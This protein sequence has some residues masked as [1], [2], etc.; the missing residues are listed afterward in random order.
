MARLRRPIAAG[1][2]LMRGATGRNTG[3]QSHHRHQTLHSSGDPPLT[4]LPSYSGFVAQAA[5]ACAVYQ[6]AS[7]VSYIAAILIPSAWVHQQAQNSLI[8]T[9]A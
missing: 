5:C 4:A 7:C 3:S 1:T 8:S 9:S 2:L 6:H